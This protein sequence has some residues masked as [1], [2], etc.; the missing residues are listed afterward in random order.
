[1]KNPRLI[2]VIPVRSFGRGTVTR[3]PSRAVT[4]PIAGTISGNT[5][6]AEPKATLPRIR[7]ATRV[8]A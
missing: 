3:I 8:T 7:E 2:A 1:M 4:T 6:P 5:R